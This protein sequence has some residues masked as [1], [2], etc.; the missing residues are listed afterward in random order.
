[1]NGFIDHLYTSL[2]TTSNYSTTT[3]LQNSQITTVPSKPFPV[4]YV[5]TSRSHRTASNSG[6]SSAS[7]AQVLSLQPS[8]QI[9]AELTTDSLSLIL[10]PTVSRPV[11]LGMK[12]ASRAYDHIFITVKQLQ[13]CWSGALSLARGRVC[14]LELLLA[15]ASAVILG[16]KSLGTQTIFYCLKIETSLFVVSYD[17][18]GYGGG[19][20]P[21]LHTGVTTDNWQLRLSSL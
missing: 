13:V 11:Y 18:Q 1:V 14:R 17:S 21:C 5:F 6:D 10:R 2:G 4:C 19:V 15:L 16:S 3:N 20:R 9:S 12:H 8:M 7:R